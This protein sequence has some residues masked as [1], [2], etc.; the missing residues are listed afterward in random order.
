MFCST[1]KQS[2]SASMGLAGESIS[3][4]ETCAIGTGVKRPATEGESEMNQISKKERSSPEG[5]ESLTEQKV[6]VEANSVGLKKKKKKKSSV[7]SVVATIE[8]NVEK[9]APKQDVGGLK[10]KKKKKALTA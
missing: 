8:L 3:E 2:V 6:A 10:Q 7:K 4:N 5:M 1:Q 9:K